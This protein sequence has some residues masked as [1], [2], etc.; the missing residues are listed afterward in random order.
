MSHMRQY[1]IKCLFIQTLPTWALI[2]TGGGYNL[3]APNFKS[4]HSSSFPSIILDFPEI[5][6]LG[7]QLNH[8]INYSSSQHSNLEPE[9]KKP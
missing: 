9:Y 3:G 8:F 6:P 4:D 5:A 1:I 7:L 2:D